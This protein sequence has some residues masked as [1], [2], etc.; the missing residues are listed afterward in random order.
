[1][2]CGTCTRVL[3]C[4]RSARGEADA[5]AGENSLRGGRDGAGQLL[6]AHFVA[7]I[8]HYVAR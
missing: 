4:C 3:V 1:M 7:R 8:Q 5:E 2:V 6:V